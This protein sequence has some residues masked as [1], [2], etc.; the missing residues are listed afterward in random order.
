MTPTVPA[1]LGHIDTDSHDAPTGKK[2][3]WYQVDVGVDW[4][5]SKRTGVFIV[6]IFQK[7]VGDA[8]FAPIYYKSPS[9]SRRQLS[10]CAQSREGSQSRGSQGG[11]SAQ[12]NPPFAPISGNAKAGTADFRLKFY[13]SSPLHIWSLVS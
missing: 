13:P 1:G 7:A 9:S 4:F 10:A 5:L 2:P 8:K 12:H 11:A 6:G 3:A